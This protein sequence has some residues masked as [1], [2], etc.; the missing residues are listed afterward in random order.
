MPTRAATAKAEAEAT[1][2]T[3]S[4]AAAV[5]AAD[6]EKENN[7]RTPTPAAKTHAKKA[8]QRSTKG[9]TKEMFCLCKGEDDGRPMVQ[10][11]NCN[12]WLHFECID[13]DPDEAAD[14][15]IYICPPCAEKTSR[16]TVSEYRATCPSFLAHIHSSL[17]LCTFLLTVVV[18]VLLYH[19]HL[20]FTLCQFGVAITCSLCGIVECVWDAKDGRTRAVDRRMSPMAMPPETL[21]RLASVMICC[22]WG[23]YTDQHTFLSLQ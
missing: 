10:C 22:I 14:I 17:A 6:G 12:D 4:R 7:V 13:L 5:V 18:I 1:R 9:K 19:Q 23:R 8:V 20:H 3:R 21:F 11:S 16:H 15:A 2:V